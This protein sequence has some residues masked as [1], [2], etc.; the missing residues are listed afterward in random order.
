MFQKWQRTACDGKTGSYSKAN[1]KKAMNPSTHFLTTT[2]LLFLAALAVIL[3]GCN[4]DQAKVYTVPKETPQTNAAVSTAST[5][6]AGHPETGGTGMTGMGS[7]MNMGMDPSTRPKL[8][9]KLPAGWSEADPGSVRV[10]SFKVNKDG[11]QADV[12][13]IPLSGAAGGD[14]ANVNRWRGQA[15]LEPASGDDLKKVAQIVEIA[16]QP[17][18]LYE[19]AGKNPGS[20]DPMRV[21]GVIQHRDDVAWFFKMTGDDELVAAQKPV[22]IEFLKTTKFEALDTTSLPVSHP[23]VDGMSMPGMAAATG[24]ISR[25]GQPVWQVPAG[26]KEAPGGQFLVAKFL[27]SGE[28]AAQATVNVSASVG[29]GGGLAANV[30]RW[31]KQLGLPDQSEAEIG[32]DTSSLEVSGG[33]GTLVTMSGIDARSGQ[34]AGLIGAMVP[35]GSQ[36]WFYKLMGDSKVVA[37]QKDAFTKFV[38]SVKY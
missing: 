34:P 3:A 28:A 36:T 2:K 11:K 22:L 24:P 32:K 37:A 33:N 7:G 19:V 21:I 20:G 38:Q 23:P 1:N 12:S 16:G 30:N 35:H 26:W 10:A 27:I 8:T 17:A 13:V 5:M 15:G 6:P 4:R 14:I 25:E 29:D 31:R 18:E 9:Y